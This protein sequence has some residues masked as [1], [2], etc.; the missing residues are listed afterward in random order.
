MNY[1]K[2]HLRNLCVFTCFYQEKVFVFVF[3]SMALMV[4]KISRVNSATYSF[5]D[6]TDFPIHVLDLRW[7][8]FH[9]TDR[10]SIDL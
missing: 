10:I 5:H 7:L 9:Y 8:K 3:S 1:K 2:V 6:A 4:S